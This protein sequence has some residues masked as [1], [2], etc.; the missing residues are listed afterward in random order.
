MQFF[1]K[2]ESEKKIVFIR[3]DNMHSH[4]LTPRLSIAIQN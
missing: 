3:I 2:I 4:D 1:D